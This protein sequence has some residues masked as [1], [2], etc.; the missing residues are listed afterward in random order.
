[1][2]CCRFRFYEKG[3]TLAPQDVTPNLSNLQLS[4]MPR[5]TGQTLAAFTHYSTTSQQQLEFWYVIER[6]MLSQGLPTAVSDRP[7]LPPGLPPTPAL[8]NKER[9]GW[10][11]NHLFV[12]MPDDQWQKKTPPLAF[13]LPAVPPVR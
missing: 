12:S 5:A 8:G 13:A 7:S 6:K 10:A 2:T 9:E 3:C 11:A 4:P 1:M